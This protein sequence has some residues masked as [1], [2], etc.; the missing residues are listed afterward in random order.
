ME[1]QSGGD[2]VGI[3]LLLEVELT[4]LAVLVLLQFLFSRCFH[5]FFSLMIYRL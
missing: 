4:L 3:G 2:V 1:G 5:V